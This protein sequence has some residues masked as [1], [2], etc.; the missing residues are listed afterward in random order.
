MIK[1]Q[2]FDILAFNFN[3]LKNSNFN[4]NITPF[5]ANKN[6]EIISLADNEVLRAIR[7]IVKHPYN[8]NV[9][10]E[11]LVN[12]KKIIKDNTNNKDKIKQINELITEQLFIPQYISITTDK[13]SDYKIIGKNG[14]YVNGKKYIRLLCGASHARTNRSMFIDSDIYKEINIILKNGVKKLN[15]VAAKYNAYYA[16]TS[17]A[18]FVVSTPRVCVVDDK[19]INMTKLVDWV[20]E[21]EYQDTI[22]RTDKELTFNLWDGMGL[23]SPQ[24]ATQW[25]NELLVDYLPS[26]FCVRCVFIK[27]MLCVFDF[28]KFAQEIANKDKIIDIY[29]KEHNINDIDIILTKS[30]FK[31]WN[32]YNS[33]NEYE[34]NLLKSGISWGISKITPKVEKD[35]IRTNYQFLQVL[36]LTQDQIIELCKPT[37]DWVYGVA[38]GNYLDTALYLLGKLVKEQDAKRLWNNIQDN[39][40]KALLLENRL[41]DDNYIRNR[42]TNSLNKR[43]RESYIGKLIISGNFMVRI[44]DPYALCEH[45]FNM[46]IKGL[47]KENEHYCN[48]WNN[49]NVDKVVAMRSPLTWRAEAH[50]LY[51]KNNEKLNDWYKYINSGIIY[52]VWGVDNML[53][54][55]ADFDFDITCTTNNSQFLEGILNSDIPVAYS[56]KKADKKN[57]NEKTLYKTDVLAYNTKIGYITNLGTTLYE[58]QSLY[59]KDTLEYKEIE[60]RLKL[61]CI[62]QNRSI[63]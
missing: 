29:L 53:E 48:Y 51:L 23:I 57:I 16:L 13:K 12:K 31:L 32:N 9:L 54:G 37:V 18:T 45:I 47:L 21:N 20:E 7:R 14:F 34:T 46:E 58:M 38:G 50:N 61:C 1:L 27:G 52:N 28:H 17:S 62:E 63:D 33:W 8:K 44:S 5:Q 19:E 43:I 41:I 24:F 56:A 55:G 3:R 26:A 40:L 2:Q 11:L 35:Y 36:D 39:F 30:Q 4:I 42:I 22:V 59:E 15:M 6:D 10:N 49:K 25:A 60:N